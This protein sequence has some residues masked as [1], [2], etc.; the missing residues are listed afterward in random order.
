MRKTFEICALD[1]PPKWQLVET[2]N[3]EDSK[4][5]SSLCDQRRANN[6]IGFLVRAKDEKE[7]FERIDRTSQTPYT[8]HTFYIL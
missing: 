8:L 7:A 2:H 1:E 3:T 6:Q 4:K 5:L